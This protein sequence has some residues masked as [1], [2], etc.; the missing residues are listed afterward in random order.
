MDF[1]KALV[2]DGEPRLGIVALP[3]QQRIEKFTINY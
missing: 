3:S 1:E 2:E